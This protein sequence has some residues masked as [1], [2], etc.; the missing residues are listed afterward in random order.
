[1]AT[2]GEIETFI[3]EFDPNDY[4]NDSIVD[5]LKGRVQFAISDQ[6]NHMI[7]EAD[8]GNPN[9]VKKIILSD[10]KDYIETY[11]PLKREENPRFSQN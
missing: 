1:M 7:E 4:P 11:V 2:D 5:I 8:F 6:I 9:E 10:V 3:T